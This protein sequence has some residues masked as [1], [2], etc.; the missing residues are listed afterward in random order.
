M[1]KCP[2]C[3]HE[4]DDNVNVCGHCC[5]GLPNGEKSVKKPIEKES[6]NSSK[7]R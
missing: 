7:K 2:Y 3:G 1:K 6:K 4:N 5:A